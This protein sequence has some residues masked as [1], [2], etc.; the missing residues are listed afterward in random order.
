LHDLAVVT[1]GRGGLGGGLEH[2]RDA[3]DVDDVERQ[4]ALANGF[5]A[6]IAVLVAEAQ[7]RVAAR[8]R[9]QGSGPPSSRS[10]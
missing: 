7:E 2:A 5:D 10:A 8:I 3:R 1:R 4:G 9:A 6:A